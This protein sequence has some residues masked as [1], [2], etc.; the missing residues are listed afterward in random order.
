MPSQ[1]KGALRAAMSYQLADWWLGLDDEER[2]QRKNY[3]QFVAQRAT[4]TKLLGNEK[5]VLVGEDGG[6][7]TYLDQVGGQRLGEIYRRFLRRFFTST[8]F[9][10]GRL[11]FF[12]TFF[13]RIGLEVINP[14]ER[15]TRAGTQPIYIECVPQDAEGTFALLYVPFDLVGKPTDI[16]GHE[17]ADD[18]RVL[19]PAANAMLVTYGFGAKTSSGFGTVANDVKDGNLKI[20]LEGRSIPLPFGSLSE[21]MVLANAIAK[22]IEPGGAR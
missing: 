12:P 5:G 20:R 9:R 10:A 22:R 18:L 13:T 1:W 6:L 16:V 2:A 11:R 17:V 19:G 4:M 3:G 7:N 14:H 15:S 8:G 21:L